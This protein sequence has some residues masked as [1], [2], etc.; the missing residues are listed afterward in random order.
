[1]K[2]DSAAS[3]DEKSYHHGGLRAALIASAKLILARE[4]LDAMSL[5]AA[6]RASGV[7]RPAPY[8]HFADK[9]A[10][11]A[12]VAT[13]GFRELRAAML[14]RMAAA[15]PGIDQ[16]TACGVGYVA[17]AVGQPALFRLMFAFWGDDFASDPDLAR[18]RDECHAVLTGTIAALLPTPDPRRQAF[19][20]IGAWSTVHGLAELI[21]K[22]V[23]APGD[24][25]AAELEPFVRRV[26]EGQ[27]HGG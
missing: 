20:S 22:G 9:N 26:L 14:T 18:A 2:N 10:L 5:R 19:N 6:A 1:M 15:G 27:P 25:G 8:H 13:D 12:A 24:F 17:F 4:G 3:I 23:I 16:L 21:N 11:L 7:S